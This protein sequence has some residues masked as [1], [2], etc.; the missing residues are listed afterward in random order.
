MATNF[1]AKPPDIDKLNNVEAIQ[2]KTPENTPEEGKFASFMNARPEETFKGSQT[3]PLEITNQGK[4]TP[5]TPP[6]IA[7]IQTQMN[8]VSSTLGDIKNQ[9]HTKGLK[10][11]QSEK[12]L[13]RS[14]LTSAN[15]NIRSA[16]A[17]T[18][19]DTGEPIDLSNK[20]NPIAKFLELVT[21]GQNQLNS[22]AEQIQALDTS[23]KSLN[24]GQLLLVQTKLQKA[25]QELEYTSILLGKSTD[26]IKTLFNVQI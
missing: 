23:G 16:A 19:V 5:S 15:E 18:G 26:M 21:D 22:A 12:Y 13:L 25:S 11:K 4:I 20:K 6:T 24:A 17:R 14:K 2:P 8:S 9:L 10:L 1:P 7:S 3:S